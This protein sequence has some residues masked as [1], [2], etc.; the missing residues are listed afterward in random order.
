MRILKIEI[1]EQVDGKLNRLAKTFP[2]NEILRMNQ[3]EA[4]FGFLAI[5]KQLNDA[6]TNPK[7]VPPPLVAAVAPAAASAGTE[8][9]GKKTSSRG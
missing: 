3:Q 6:L 9:K 5:V 2:L 7:V 4:G 1:E 8:K